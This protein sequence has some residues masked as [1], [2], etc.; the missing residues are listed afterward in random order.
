MI[1]IHSHILPGIDD[2]ARNLDESIEMIQVARRTGTT[3]I[4]ATPHANSTFKFDLVRVDSKLNE[5]RASV[6]PDIVLYRGC[7]FHLTHKN[8]LDAVASPFKYCLDGKRYLLV[9]LSDLVVFPNTH[10]QYQKLEAA[11]LKLIVTHPERN[12]I[13]QQRPE[14]IQEWVSGGRLMQV[15]AA[16]LLGRFGKRAEQLSHRLLD[17]GMVHFLAS[18]GHDPIHRPPRLDE[19]YRWV[20]RRYGKQWADVLCLHN[21]KCAIEGTDLDLSRFPPPRE[22]PAG[23]WARLFRSR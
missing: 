1:D 16:S 21:P 5:L 3:A 14:L 9:E 10:E 11:G 13:L 6:E 7:D 4:A 2:G 23:F 17:E 22:D 12:L 18:D 19:G 8:I 15:T 20:E